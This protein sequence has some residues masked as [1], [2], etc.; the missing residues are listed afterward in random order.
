MSRHPARP[1]RRS[2]L[3]VIAAAPLLALPALNRAEAAPLAIVL[4]R[5][6]LDEPWSVAFLPGGGALV[7]ER[8]G[9]LLRLEPSGAA[10]AV[11]G[12]PEVAVGGQ[13]GLFDVVVPRDFARN[14]EI[15]FSF[16]RPQGR[17]A[18]TA[19]AAARLAADGR[20]I[21]DLRILFEM[22]PGGRGGRHFGGRIVELADGTV[23][24]TL[25][26]RGSADLAQ[27]MTRHEGKLVRVARDGSVPADNPFAADSGARPEIWSLGHR[28]PQGA[29]LDAAGQLWVSEHGP[30]GG[31]EVNLVRR[32]ANY[33]WPLATHGVAYT[34]LPIAGPAMPGTEPPAHVWVPSIA[35]SGHAVLSGRLVPEWRGRHVVGSLKFDNLTLLDP[36]RPG[37]GGWAEERI[38]GPETAR[39][40]DV[41]EA[42]DGS[43][44]FLSVGQG[45]VFRLGRPGA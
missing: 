41:R 44:W 16:A 33:G 26:D 12:L 43:V 42:P 32:G 21:E 34:G 6:G 37:P 22:A 7:T 11:A 38:A 15:L 31:D 29:T 27:D 45:A 9:R 10:A 13:G 39:V 4:V 23:M 30:R 19:L 14:R 25:G 5:D 20:R 36:S 3:A 2:A 35:P 1:D 24:L 17:G 18:G 40:R 8:G 28:N